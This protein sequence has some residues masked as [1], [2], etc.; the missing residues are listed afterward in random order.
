MADKEI[1]KLTGDETLEDLVNRKP[2]TK[3]TDK[4]GGAYTAAARVPIELERHITLF[5]EMPNSPY[6][7][8]G[9]VVRDAIYLGLL[10][11][12]TRYGKKYAKMLK[13]DITK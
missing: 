8:K 11:L 1:L 13:K 7:L 9:D 4:N 10:V 12:H 5:V 3:S 6:M 2:F